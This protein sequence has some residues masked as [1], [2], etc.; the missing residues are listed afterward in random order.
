LR[1]HA[2][3]IDHRAHRELAFRKALR[4]AEGAADGILTRLAGEHRGVTAATRPSELPAQGADRALHR[5][6]VGDAGE[7]EQT[8]VSALETRSG[9][10]RLCARR[11]FR[12]RGLVERGLERRFQLRR[13]GRSPRAILHQRLQDDLLHG[14]GDRRELRRTGRAQPDVRFA[15]RLRLAREGRPPGDHLEQDHAD[16]VHVGARVQPRPLLALLGTCVLRRPSERGA[17]LAKLARGARQAEVDEPH[18][19]RGEEDVLRLQVEVDVPR[20]VDGAHHVAQR[21]RDPPEFRVAQRP[22]LA[23]ALRQRGRLQ[24]LKGEVGRAPRDESGAEDRRR[25]RRPHGAQRLLLAAQLRCGDGIA[26]GRDLERDAGAV[27]GGGGQHDAEATAPQE[28]LDAVPGHGDLQLGSGGFAHRVRP[29]QSCPARTIVSQL[30]GPQ[31]SPQ[32]LKLEPVPQLSVTWQMPSP[33]V[34]ST[35]RMMR[36]VRAR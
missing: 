36:V 25:G 4:R 20:C 27:S 9:T 30:Q 32:S 18:P 10:H 14:A 3:D 16:R 21:Q 7:E 5:S 22:R 24:E 26:G 8:D 33:Q 35:S 12:R 19:S 13:A 6:R 11:G 1:V 17:P 23:E 15:H 2:R 28:P 31:S 29:G 34:Y